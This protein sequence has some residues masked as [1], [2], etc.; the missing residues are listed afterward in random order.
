MDVGPVVG[1]GIA[2]VLALGSVIYSNQ[3]ARKAAAQTQAREEAAKDRA[4]DVER[5]RIEADAYKRARESYEA[6]LRDADRRDAQHRAEIEYLNKRITERDQ[7]IEARDKL[8]EGLQEELRRTRNQVR[9]IR[10]SNERMA[11]RLDVAERAIARNTSRA[12]VSERRADASDK[13]ADAA[14]EQ[15]DTDRED[16]A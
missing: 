11:Q 6:S 9:D 2:G 1:S 7:R 15:A 16:H 8:I 13:R 4:E 10:E 14:E 5:E 3:M 12:D